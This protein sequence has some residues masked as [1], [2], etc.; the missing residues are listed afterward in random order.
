M[1]MAEANDLSV[2][3][4][5]KEIDGYYNIQLTYEGFLNKL[6]NS[7]QDDMKYAMENVFEPSLQRFNVSMDE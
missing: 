7:S 2:A 6:S 4:F 5:P 1:N 3:P